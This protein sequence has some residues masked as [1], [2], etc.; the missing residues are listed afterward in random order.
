MANILLHIGFPK[1]GSTYLQRWFE[2]HPEI[3]F[4]PK[5]I[6]GGFYHAWELAK[7]AQQS[8]KTP[9]HFVLSCEDLTLWKS[10]PNIYGL[11]GTQSYN[12]KQYQENICVSLKGIYPTAKILI[13]TR[14]YEAVFSSVYA[15]YLASA[16]TYTFKEMS[17][18]LWE[19]FTTMFDYTRVIE[20]YRSKFDAAN[21]IVLPFEL[22]R[23]KPEQF[24]QLIER[25]MDVSPSFKFSNAKVNAAYDRKTL[26]AYRNA[27]V[28]VYKLLKPFPASLQTALYA[29][30]TR[31]VRIKKP[32]PLLRWVSQ[33]VK[34]E[35]SMDGMN[36][37][38]AAMKGQAEVLG[39]EELY[40]P[41]LKD[42]LL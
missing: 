36:E 8:N 4:Q 11:R 28:L 29:K 30:Y 2:E 15:Q 5:Y 32:H 21:V 18:E 14:G 1:S 23:D 17:T 41:Y 16:G 38:L 37:L 31:E 24:L 39:S 27:S 13:V 9:K 6:A 35:V 20:L 12:Y 42:Y 19:M 33:F 10:Q 40:K 3:Y 26:T 25:E 22:L 34:N 7:H